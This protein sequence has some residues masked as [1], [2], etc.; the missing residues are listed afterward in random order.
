MPLSDAPHCLPPG[1]K[2]GLGE[3]KAHLRE[4]VWKVGQQRLFTDVEQTNLCGVLVFALWR[5]E[6]AS[7]ISEYV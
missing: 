4:V 2:A 7:T 1:V 6:R 3:A 5:N